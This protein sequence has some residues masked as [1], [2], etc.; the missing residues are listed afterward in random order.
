MVETWAFKGL[1]YHDFGIYVYT[2]QLQGAFGNGDVAG[3][4]ILDLVAT[5]NWAYNPTYGLPKWSYAGCL[6]FKEGC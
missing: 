1:V 6:S 4:G 5:Y 2:I 3:L